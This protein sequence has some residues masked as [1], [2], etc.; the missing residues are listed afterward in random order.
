MKKL[1]YLLLLAV[2]WPSFAAR[3]F[4]VEVILFK[5]N[6][7]PEQVNES[8]PE[9]LKQVDMQGALSLEDTAALKAK[10]VTILPSSQYALDAQYNKLKKH[11][12]FTPLAHIAWRQGDQNQANAPK[13]Y[14]T[15]GRDFSEQFLPDG[16][17]KKDVEQPTNAISIDSD[18]NND[19]ITITADNSTSLLSNSNNN[20]DTRSDS[21]YQL[22]GMLQVYVQHY[23]FLDANLDLREP[24]RREVIMT[25][26]LLESIVNEQNAMNVNT[27]T[28][29][30]NGI[31]VNSNVQIGHL[32]EVK[33]NIK[34]EE[35]LKPYRLSQQRRMRSGEI[36]YLD[37]PLLGVIIQ[38]RRVGS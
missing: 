6:I 30:E 8:W 28:A 12:G 9:Q 32:Q 31:D 34:V 1:I 25:K 26:P 33:K 24:S 21:L 37:N 13:L 7:N 2:S 11:A 36:H 23:L 27:D 38:V 19:G 3:Q 17:S 15:A 16:R 35:F 29:T 14:I 10:G 4:D 5:R 22:N 20:A 18:S